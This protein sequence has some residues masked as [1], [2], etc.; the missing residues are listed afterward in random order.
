MKALIFDRDAGRLSTTWK[1]GALLYRGLRRFDTT[2]GVTS[3]DDA[4]DWL[5][6]AQEPIEEI[7]Y[8]GHGKWGCA[9]VGDEVLDASS[10]VSRRRQWAAIRERLAPDALVWFRTCETFGANRGI[11]FAERLADFLGA[12]VA[13]HTYVIHFY[14]SGL[15]SLLPGHR[16]DW[17]PTEG[18]LEGTA[19][20]P[21]RARSSSPWA[22]HTVT[23]LTGHV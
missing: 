6:G 22:P 8:W 17:S 23:C 18:L 2:R 9:L 11:D 7:Q 4:L 20:T 14:Q 13:G 15:H 3:W 21:R 1:A 16:A 12:R 19:E 5:A 10:L